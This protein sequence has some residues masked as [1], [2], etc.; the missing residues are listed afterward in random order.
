MSNCLTPQN[1][2][3][4]IYRGE[5]PRARQTPKSEQ[6]LYCLTMDAKTVLAELKKGPN[7]PRFAA[8]HRQHFTRALAEYNQERFRRFVGVANAG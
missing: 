7:H 1:C 6:C 4:C 8:A 5:W 2:P 3:T